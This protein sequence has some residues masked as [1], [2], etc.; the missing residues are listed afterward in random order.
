VINC[1]VSASGTIPARAAPSSRRIDGSHDRSG[2]EFL[3]IAVECRCVQEYILAAIVC[4]G[5]SV[6]AYVVDL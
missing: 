3:L 4:C 2:R 6:S 5:K 1:S